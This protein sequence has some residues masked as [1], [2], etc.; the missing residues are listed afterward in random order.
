MDQIADLYDSPRN[1]TQRENRTQ[2]GGQ[3]TEDLLHQALER[4]HTLEIQLQRERDMCYIYQNELKQ[5][6]EALYTFQ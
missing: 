1:S 6:Q 2:Q 5:Q 3:G 4:I